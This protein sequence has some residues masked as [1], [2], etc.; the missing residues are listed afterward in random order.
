MGAL[1]DYIHL[2]TENYIKYGVAKKG[3]SPKHFSGMGNFLE[4]RIAAIK[5]IDE[6][7]I[8]TL[9]MRLQQNTVQQENADKQKSDTDF[10]EKLDTLYEYIASHSSIGAIGQYMGSTSGLKGYSKSYENIQSKALSQGEVEKRKSLLK[11]LHTKIAMI[12]KKGAEGTVSSAELNELINLYNQA[13]GNQNFSASTGNQSILGKIQDAANELSYNSWISH[14]SGEFGE[15]L[16]AMCADKVES[17]ATDEL[18]TFFKQAVVGSKRTSITL[19]K[20]KV[21]K[22]LSSYLSTD[23]LGNSYY[24]GTTQD[25]VDVKI[26]VN[27]EEVLANVKEYYGAEKVTLQANVSLFSSLAY[28]EQYDQFGTHWLNMHTGSLKGKGRATADKILKQEIAYEALVSGNPLKKGVSQANVFVYIDRQTG[29]IFVKDTKTLL[30]DESHRI[31]ISPQ[32]EGIK[33]TNRF[34]KKSFEDRI[35]SILM[36][37][38]GKQLKVSMN[39]L[40]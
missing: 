34:S 29:R 18:E 5:P 23:K 1:G 35:A 13:G 37:A 3:E 12:N 2:H 27:Q 38:H 30:T 25:K 21:A 36:Q 33:F 11:E 17:L 28:L 7:T 10:Q 20:T 24:L 15:H 6:K 26:T 8:Q 39:V 16:T 40:N 4:N 31:K 14:V 9:E 19:D 22:D 32:L